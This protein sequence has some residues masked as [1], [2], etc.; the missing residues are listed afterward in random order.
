MDINLS[1]DIYNL[2]NNDNIILINSYSLGRYYNIEGCVDMTEYYSKNMMFTF[3]VNECKIIDYIKILEN[4]SYNIN[5]DYK[6]R[7][8]INNKYIIASNNNSKIY[9]INV[10]DYKI[11]KELDIYNYKIF[12]FDENKIFI[13]NR[14]FFYDQFHLKK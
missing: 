9:I 5:S 2:P 12:G 1:F 4:K 7:I 14:R 11:I 13:L 8:I 10:S 6:L 3:N